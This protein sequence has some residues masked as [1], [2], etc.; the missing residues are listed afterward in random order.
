MKRYIKLFIGILSLASFQAFAQSSLQLDMSTASVT[1]SASGRIVI[2]GVGVGG[3]LYDAQLQWDP[4]N[5][6][7]DL[8]PETIVSAS[9]NARVCNLGTVSLRETPNKP[10]Q[11]E[12]VS[13]N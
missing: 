11:S 8:V 9:G 1:K 10:S 12:G 6:R 4:Y 2:S 5:L 7:F 13:A 3:S